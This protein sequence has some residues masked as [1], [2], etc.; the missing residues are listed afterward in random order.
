MSMDRCR[1][2][3]NLDREMS[4]ENWIVCPVIPREV[5]LSGSSKDCPLYEPLQHDPD[6]RP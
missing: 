2:C 1:A 6:A 3:A 4:S 5:V